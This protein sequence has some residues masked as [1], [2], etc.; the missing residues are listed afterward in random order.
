[1]FEG[2]IKQRYAARQLRPINRTIFSLLRKQGKEHLHTLIKVNE[3]VRQGGNP[4]AK[5]NY[6]RAS[7]NFELKSR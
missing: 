6:F 3:K 1:M 7:N 4:N 2:M 5:Q